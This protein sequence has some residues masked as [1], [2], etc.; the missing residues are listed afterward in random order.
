MSTLIVGETGAGKSLSELPWFRHKLKEKSGKLVFDF[1]GQFTDLCGEVAVV[2]GHAD[3]IMYDKLSAEKYVLGYKLDFKAKS[4]G[5]EERLVDGLSQSFLVKRGYKDG[6]DHPYLDK[7]FKWASRLVLRQSAPLNSFRYALQGPDYGGLLENAD[8]E[9]WLAFQRYERLTKGE[10]ERQ[11]EP[12]NRVLESIFDSVTVSSRLDGGWDFIE[13][14]RK[15]GIHLVN[16]LG[17]SPDKMRTFGNLLLVHAIECAKEQDFALDV[18]IDEAQRGFITPYLAEQLVQIRG[19]DC[20]VTLMC[21]D[22]SFPLEFKETIFQGCTRHAWYRCASRTVREEAA[23]DLIGMLDR[24]RVHHYED[25][26]VSVRGPTVEYDAI[27][28]N[29]SESEDEDGRTRTT[30][31]E[32]VTTRERVLWETI[33]QR[34]PHYESPQSQLIWLQQEISALGD[35]ERFVRDKYGCRKQYVYPLPKNLYPCMPGL[36][37]RRWKRFLRQLREKPVY[38]P[39]D[40][41]PWIPAAAAR[42]GRKGKRRS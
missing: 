19:F 26:F 23:C 13:H 1:H 35:G 30:K 41:A 9:T 4:R 8:M 17:V 37:K 33:H 7:A 10:R 38:R 12:G 39:A 40:Q 20:S 6:F 42:H 29:S 28:K 5:H 11:I 22:V 34:I 31:G 3:K 32:S 27:T 15:G 24:N 14:L 36:S 2:D 18:W 25:R 21:Q 16:G